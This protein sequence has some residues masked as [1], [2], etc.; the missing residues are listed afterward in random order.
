MVIGSVDWITGFAV[1]VLVGSV[2]GNLILQLYGA[3][4]AGARFRPNLNLRHPG[5]ILFLKLAV[6]IMLA[7]SLTFTDDWIMRWFGSYLQPASITWLSYG[8]T[9]MRV[10]LTAVGQA[11][12]VV[13]FPLLA[14][15]YSE[16]KFDQL[17]RMLN[18][19]VKGLFLFVIPIS[20]LTI[21]QSSTVIR[22]VFSNTRLRPGD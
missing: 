1:G 20:A 16:G 7:L 22:F 4:L 12:G 8:K 21:A 5:F 3:S 15:L 2:V 11:V 18:T 10:P 14:Q 13:S 19:T 9:L 6:P 17:N